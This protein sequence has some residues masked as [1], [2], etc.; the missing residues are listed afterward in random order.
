MWQKIS[1]YITENKLHY[2]T[3]TKHLILFRVTIA[4]SSVQENF[5]VH[6][7]CVIPNCVM[8]LEHGHEDNRSS[9]SILKCSDQLWQNF[10]PAH[11]LR[12]VVQLGCHGTKETVFFSFILD[13]NLLQKQKRIHQVILEVSPQLAAACDDVCGVWA[14]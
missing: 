4:A 14:G 6:V 11:I 7:L 2:I 3:K 9:I 10:M 8:H 1:S 13:L 5:Y 12:E